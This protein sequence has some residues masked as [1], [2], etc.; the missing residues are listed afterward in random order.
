MGTMINTRRR[1][2]PFRPD[3]RRARYD[4]LPENFEFRDGGCELSPSCLRCPLERCRYDAPGG[5]RTIRRTSRDEALLRRR[6][7][8]LAVNALAREFGITK[9]TVFRVLARAREVVAG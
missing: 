1:S 6:E 5:V 8:G 2:G 7:E 9:R 3:G 4:A